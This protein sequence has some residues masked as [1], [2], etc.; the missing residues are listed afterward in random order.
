M[1]QAVENSIFCYFEVDYSL[2]T[3]VGVARS[4]ATPIQYLYLWKSP[5]SAVPDVRDTDA[6]SNTNNV[7]IANGGMRESL[8]TIKLAPYHV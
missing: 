3:G 4:T 8:F 7:S 6:R 1:G 5:G 2:L